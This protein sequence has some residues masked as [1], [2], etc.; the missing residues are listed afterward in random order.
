MHCE[1]ATFTLICNDSSYCVS[2][3]SKHIRE[4]AI[5]NCHFHL[6][7]H[8]T[9]LSNFVNLNAMSFLI[10]GAG[11][12]GLSTAL[13]LQRCWPNAQ[14]TIIADKF[15]IETTSDVAAGIFRPG[16]SFAG[17]TEAIT[18]YCIICVQLNVLNL[19][20]KCY[21]RWMIDSYEYWNNLRCEVNATDCGVKQLSVYAF[22]NTDKSL[23]RVSFLERS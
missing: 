1:F 21:R 11:V 2:I 14:V 5:P 13:E 8:I 18:R 15:G 12:V 20:T 6:Y 3:S 16:S 9:F 23:V 10:L 22:S 17:P 19:I 4:Y 7:N